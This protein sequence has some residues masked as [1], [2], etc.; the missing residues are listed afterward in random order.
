MF[1]DGKPGLFLE[2]SSKMDKRVNKKEFTP[3]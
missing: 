1:P 2:E 3:S